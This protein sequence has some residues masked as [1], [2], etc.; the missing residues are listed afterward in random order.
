MSISYWVAKKFGALLVVFYLLVMGTL[1]VSYYHDT[2]TSK[3]EVLAAYYPA[4]RSYPSTTKNQVVREIFGMP[5]SEND[6]KVPAGIEIISYTD[7]GAV[8]RVKGKNQ[9]EV[10]TNKVVHY[11]VNPDTGDLERVIAPLQEPLNTLLNLHLRFM[12]RVEDGVGGE[13]GGL[14]KMILPKVVVSF[15]YL[16][17]VFVAL[18]ALRRVDRS[19]EYKSGFSLIY[20]SFVY[21]PLAVIVISFLGSNVVDAVRHFPGSLD[22]M[23]WY[24][25]A[26]WAAIFAWPLF[27]GLLS[28]LDVLRSLLR[29]DYN[30]AVGHAA[31][32]AGGIISIP[33]VTI[34]VLFVIAVCAMYL[35]YRV[36]RRV[37]VP[38]RIKKALGRA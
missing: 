9:E 18:F 5:A 8:I 27:V 14:Q 25:V 10:D 11:L 35:A 32:L 33:L 22:F 6:S 36:G 13:A 19:T 2:G 7:T 15:V 28:A 26:G 38:E 4:G 1:V 23:H 21:W 34:G 37:L 24:V 3:P 16:G 31:V 29:G 17:I 30:L 12:K 20:A